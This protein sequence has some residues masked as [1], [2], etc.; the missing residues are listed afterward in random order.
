MEGLHS[1]PTSHL[2]FGRPEKKKKKQEE[3]KVEEREEK[4]RRYRVVG[5]EMMT[6]C[7]DRRFGEDFSDVTIFKGN[8]FYSIYVVSGV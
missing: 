5:R 8:D 2:T 7:K 4:R 6:Q 1:Y 3:T